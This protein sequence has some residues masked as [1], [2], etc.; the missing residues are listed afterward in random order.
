MVDGNNILA[1]SKIYIAIIFIVI[2]IA[3]S[4]NPSAMNTM[5]I[6]SSFH[7]THMITCGKISIKI[8]VVAD[9]GNCQNEI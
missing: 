7:Y 5:C 9:K 3:T 1:T 8:N 6:M 2:F 4:K